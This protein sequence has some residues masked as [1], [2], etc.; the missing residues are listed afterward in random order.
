[1][2]SSTTAKDAKNRVQ[3]GLNI[4]NPIIGFPNLLLNG[5]ETLIDYFS[6]ITILGDVSFGRLLNVV[7]QL[8]DFGIHGGFDLL[9]VLTAKPTHALD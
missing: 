1:M 2:R 9:H 8:V 4:L 3:F 7:A 5:S 6:E